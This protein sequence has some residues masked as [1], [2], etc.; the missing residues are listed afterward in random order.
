MSQ[1]ALQRQVALL[2]RQYGESFTL[3]RAGTTIGG[4]G[5]FAPLDNS[6]VAIFFDANEQVG[7]LRPALNLYVDGGGSNPPLPAD[8]FF[9]DGR[10]WT[11]RKTFTYRISGTAILLLCLCD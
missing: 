4:I 5:L 11:V 7:L 9:R 1:V 2:L 10:L 6:N 3:T 8:V